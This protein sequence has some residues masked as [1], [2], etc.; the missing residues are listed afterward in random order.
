MA[1]EAPK[2]SCTVSERS[3][4][5]NVRGVVEG[6]LG[7]VQCGVVAALTKDCMKL[8]VDWEDV[9]SRLE[10]GCEARDH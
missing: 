6:A 10:E 8:Q 3:S 2:W 5:E 7:E 4:S 9:G 1:I